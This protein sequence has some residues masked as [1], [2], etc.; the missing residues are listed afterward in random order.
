M[1]H[2]GSGSKESLGA[3]SA[4]QQ[5][6][7]SMQ[8]CRCGYVNIIYTVILHSFPLKS[9]VFLLAS[10]LPTIYLSIE[11]HRHLSARLKKWKTSSATL[12]RSTLLSTHLGNTNSSS[13]LKFCRYNN[14]ADNFAYWTCFM[15]GVTTSNSSAAPRSSH[16]LGLLICHSDSLTT[17][18]EEKGG[19]KRQL[20][21]TETHSPGASASTANAVTLISNWSIPTL[22][23]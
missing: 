11:T 10:C 2:W 8:R 3:F 18:R 4:A 1:L 16:M 12:P 17:E 22:F 15:V 6:R 7:I 23:L 21:L 20:F 9:S 19:G 5:L 14:F 13:L